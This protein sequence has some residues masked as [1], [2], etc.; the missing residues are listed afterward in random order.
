MKKIIHYLASFLIPISIFLFAMYL[1]D[2]Y[3]FGDTSIRVIDAISQYPAFF[4]GLKDGDLFTFKIGLGTNFYTI[5]TT[6]LASPLSFLYLFF[7]S[8]QFDLFF[9]ILVLLKIGLI[10]LNMNILLNYKKDRNKY[11]L[12]FSTIYA[13]SGFVSLYYFNYQ[14]LD[15]LYMLPLIMIGIEKIV[16]DN[17]NLMYF[18]TLTLMIIFHYYTA[19]MICIFSVIY[20]FFLLINSELNKKDKK[21]RIIKFFVTSL[22]CGLC[23]SFIT[24]P[25]IYS[26]MQGRSSSAE[27]LDYLTFNK[28]IFSLFYN[29]TSGSSFYFDITY[30]NAPSFITIFIIVLFI[31]L[32]FDKKLSKKYRLSLLTI[33]IIYILS[34]SFNSLYYF[35]HVFQQ[36][37][38][39]PGRFIFVFNCFLVLITYKYFTSKNFEIN[40]KIKIFITFFLLGVVII[41]YIYKIMNS[42]GFIY[43][44]RFLI[45]LLL[46]IGIS[47]YY[48]FLG[49]NKKVHLLTFFLIFLEILINLICSF[50]LLLSYNEYKNLNIKEEVE[51]NIEIQEIIKDISFNSGSFQRLNINLSNVNGLYNN[52]NDVDYFA[53]L[54]NFN[55]F[56][57]LADYN[58][59]PKSTPQFIYY[60]N[61][62]FVNSFLSVS[63]Y[64]FEY[65]N[66]YFRIKTENVIDSVGLMVSSKTETNWQNNNLT[67]IIDLYNE[68]TNYKYNLELKTMYPEE[69]LK[70]LEKKDNVYQLVNK[71]ENGQ[72]IF[73]YK[74]LEDCYINY[75]FKWDY[76]YKNNNYEISSSDLK[77]IYVNDEVVVALNYLKS[78]DILKI[79]INIPNNL[80]SIYIDSEF[81]DYVNRKKY[82][83]CIEDLNNNILTNI[84]IISNGFI[85]DLRVSNT[86]DLLLLTIPYDDSIQIFANNKE[87]SYKKYLNGII[88]IKLNEGNYKIRFVYNV[89]GL[90]ISLILSIVSLLIFV[91]LKVL[92]KNVV[93]RY[94]YIDNKEG[95]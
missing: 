13:L 25:S 44:S 90:K 57:F 84:K 79:V 51:K 54:Y 91:V 53:S 88:G 92:E 42:V 76:V 61:D 67:N 40:K 18:I 29:F 26:L 59:G 35:W 93:K 70:N 56:T 24:I 4:E 47:V 73:E 8:Y 31:L 87:E 21:R 58:L 52:Y 16:N 27:G 45:L 63:E 48:I 65:K 81:L 22:F 66:K 1:M 64:I 69:Y 72:I 33:F 89:K 83:K 15:A 94:N 62:S 5:F 20:F 43:D 2:L 85:A 78:G 46:N 19:Y 38:F 49:N 9:V 80:D 32:L 37:I 34:L 82:E 74:I 6:Y 95:Y 3:P 50:N 10:G 77:T 55:L 71:E 86:K 41:G 7:E 68:F 30:G 11:S 23:S 17:K 75:D 39:F 12:I 36:P 60:E 14:F 28:N